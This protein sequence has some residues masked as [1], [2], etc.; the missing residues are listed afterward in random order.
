MQLDWPQMQRSPL[1]SFSV[2]QVRRAG[3]ALLLIAALAYMA[4]TIRCAPE[5]YTGSLQGDG[6]P[7]IQKDAPV[8]LFSMIQRKLGYA[9]SNGLNWIARTSDDDYRDLYRQVQSILTEE[10]SL[11][12]LP[13]ESILNH[14]LYRDG[15]FPLK[16]KFFRNTA[17]L[18]IITDSTEEEYML[19]TSKGLDVNY[20]VTVL[21]DHSVSKIIATPARISSRL[22][23]NLYSADSGL[24]YQAD[25]EHSAKAEPYDRSL[26]LGEL[27]DAY[28]PVMTQTLAANRTE[29]LAQL[30]KKLATEIR[31][32]VAPPPASADDDGAADDLGF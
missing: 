1:F 16:V 8:A 31:F 21:S 7:A 18:P 4:V 26:S 19:R 17:K 14:A 2:P 11:E 13:R 5:L 3:Q 22:I 27:Y 10:L 28:D 25:L 32:A 30:R 20:Y 23:F 12:P 6:K 15:R 9:N 29:L 24:I